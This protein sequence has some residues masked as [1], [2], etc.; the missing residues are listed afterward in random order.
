MVGAETA[1]YL[2]TRGKR[3]TIVEMLDN[4]A[5][6]M[7]RTS[8]LFLIFSL[9]ELGVK[10]LTKVTAKKITDQG[11]IVDRKG[12]E[13]FIKADT[14]VVALGATP[15]EELFGQLEK[16]EIEI[17]KIGDCTTARRLPDAVGEGF[18]TALKL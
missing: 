17:H 2:A 9:D 10:M 13:E 1:E 5:G 3:V 14:V 15:N 16:L 6:D 8:R 18:K 4:V 11:V 7:D 12:E